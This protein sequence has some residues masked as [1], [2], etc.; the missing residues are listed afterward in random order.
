MALLGV[1]ALI[2]G[3]VALIMFMIWATYLAKV[4]QLR[5]FAKRLANPELIL[6]HRWNPKLAVTSL[7]GSYP[8]RDGREIKLS[9]RVQGGGGGNSLFTQ[10][11]M[12]VPNTVS[13]FEVSHA[14]ALTRFGR[15][16][17]LV[18][19]VKTGHK[20]V[21]DKYILAGQEGSL[22]KLFGSPDLEA[23]I[24]ALFSNPGITKLVLQDGWLFCETRLGRDTAARFDMIFR[25]LSRI[26][27]QCERLQV[28]VKILGETP[29]FAWTAGK[30]TPHC[31]YCRDDVGLDND[32][33]MACSTCNTV[34]HSA[35]YEEAGGCTIF[36]CERQAPRRVAS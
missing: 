6:D 19:D 30:G 14:G 17:G 16:L 13:G 11:S 3:S 22:R 33:V 36:G 4:S 1:L 12:R 23:G 34:H 15:W 27:V 28:V 18:A 26:A 8:E 31:P 29:R 24:D 25:A 32:D 10:Y 5:A 21:D 35:C 9:F 2:A 20:E 7:K